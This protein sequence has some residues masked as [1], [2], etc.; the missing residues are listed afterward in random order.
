LPI[1]FVAMPPRLI[2]SQFLQD[3]Y[4]AI[5]LDECLSA[6]FDFGEHS[7]SLLDHFLSLGSQCQF[8]ASGCDE[9]IDV[10]HARPGHL[11]A[12]GEQLGQRVVGLLDVLL[13]QVVSMVGFGKFR[14]TL[15]ASFLA[16]P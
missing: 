16:Q 12:L 3:S 7:F 6:T 8:I 11:S 9:A 13:Q 15:V 1:L 4:F 10:D 5:G 14:A 2:F